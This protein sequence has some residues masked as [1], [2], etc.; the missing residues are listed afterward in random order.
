MPTVFVK[1]F[2][3]VFLGPFASKVLRSGRSD[4]YG[5]SHDMATSSIARR[6]PPV[7]EKS[8]EV[9][10]SACVRRLGLISMP[11][12]TSHV[13]KVLSRRHAT[14]SGDSNSRTRRFAHMCVYFLQKVVFA[15]NIVSDQIHNETG[16]YNRRGDA[17]LG[18][19]IACGALET[20]AVALRFLSR[21]K[22]GANW[23][24]DDWLIL[25]ALIPNYAMVII[26]GFGKSITDAAIPI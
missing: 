7:T 19:S 13:L 6:S 10:K 3:L 24:I 1:L 20:V 22:L 18:V 14:T 16:P 12:G 26:F 17:I 23:R 15:Y 2:R 21:R 11:Q 5:V 25:V 9:V 4:F 8:I